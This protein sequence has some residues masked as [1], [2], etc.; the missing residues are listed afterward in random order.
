MTEN[1]AL[2]RRRLAKERAFLWVCRFLTLI[3][4]AVLALLLIHTLR[5]GLQ[6]L[7][8]EFLTN[9]AS[10][11]PA[12]AGIKAPLMGS[13]W[14]MILTAV[15]SIP[16]GVATAVFLEEYASRD[17]PVMRF[18]EINISNLAGMPSIVYGLLG[19]SIFVRFFA[20]EDSIL[21]AALTL[22]LLVLPV[23]VIA[24]AHAIRAVPKNLRLGA[25]ALGAR[26]WQVV[27]SHV[28]PS[29]AA[30]IM[31]GII[32]SISRAIGE[33]APLIIVGALSYVAFV[34]ESLFDPF[35]VLPVQIYNWAS[36]PQEAFHGL[37]AAAIVVLLA[38]LL[39]M[40]LV[41]VL[42]RNKLGRNKL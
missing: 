26:R 5:Q 24:S 3:A 27:L 16:L 14:I 29:A 9:F 20:F 12:K 41:A 39:T 17:N 6:W 37:A 32:L 25:F 22:S 18:I 38:V 42:I 1:N 13:F 30:G 10:R 15:I 28:L 40:N 21:T 2:R 35:T 11:F 4:V 34:P 31:T 19:L 7:N 33:S 36:R 8:P 23:I